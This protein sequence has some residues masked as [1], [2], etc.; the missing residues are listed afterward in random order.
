MFHIDMLNENLNYSWEIFQRN[1][2]KIVRE[3]SLKHLQGNE[4]AKEAE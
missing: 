2:C 4:T 3:E 1:D